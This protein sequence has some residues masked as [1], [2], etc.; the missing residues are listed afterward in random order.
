MSFE[1]DALFE[2][3]LLTVFM[4]SFLDIKSK[5]KFSSP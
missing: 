1:I 3:S 5:Q 2:G 4:I